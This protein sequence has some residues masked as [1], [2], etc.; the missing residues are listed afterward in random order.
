MLVGLQ[1]YLTPR[2]APYDS[3][4]G[5]R[6]SDLSDDATVTIVLTCYACAIVYRYTGSLAAFSCLWFFYLS[7]VTDP[8]TVTEENCRSLVSHFPYDNAIFPVEKICVTCGFVKPARSK[9]C[10]ACRRYVPA[11]IQESA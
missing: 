4:F 3:N 2:G 6:H 8:G 5:N 7:S 10:S 9:H 1:L 11:G